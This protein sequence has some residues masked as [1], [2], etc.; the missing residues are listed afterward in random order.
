MHPRPPASSNPAQAPERRFTGLPASPGVAIGP[1]VL[2]RP[3]ESIV[4][5]RAIVLE[6]VPAEIDRL[7]EAL[8]RT[9]QQLMEARQKLL[10]QAQEGEAAV[11]D[12]HLL[13]LEDTTL[14]EAVRQKITEQLFNADYAYE[15]LARTYAK[16]MRALE[17][18][19]LAE[20]AVDI[21]DVCRRVLRN[22]HPTEGARGMDWLAAPGV[23]LAHD[24]SPF[25]IVSLHHQHLLGFATQAGSHTSHTTIM[26]RSLGLPAVVGLDHDLL[27]TLEAG[28]EVLLDG[29]RGLLILNPTEETRLGYRI[30]QERRHAD[31]SRLASLRRL[32]TVTLDGHRIRLLANAGLPEDLPVLQEHG[33]EGIG[34]YR[35]EFLYLNRSE[36]PSE[37]EQLE[38]YRQ[39]AQAIA[40]HPL[41]IRTF[42]LGVDKKLEA[43]PMPEEVNPAL[44]WRGIRLCLDRSDLFQTQLRAI[45]RTAMEY[46]V[47]I[48]LPMVATLEEVHAARRAIDRARES[49]VS[50]GTPPPP[51]V[52]LGVMVEVPSVAIAAELF[53]PEVQFFSL[54]TNDLIQY[55]MAADRTNERTAQL[56]QPTHPAVLRL[57][58]MVAQAGRKHHV[59]VTVCGEMA[60]D[61][62]LAPV[63]AGLGVQNLSLHAPQIPTLKRALRSITLAKAAQLARA[64]LHSTSQE[65]SRE[66]LRKF[67]RSAYPDLMEESAV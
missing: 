56:Y 8:V 32:P 16:K 64:L 58:Q 47:Q 67:A 7:E 44:G 9:R 30:Q 4:A 31:Q 59:P 62:L 61:L 41:T 18:A 35:T 1:L 38:A 60:G 45:L 2:L 26:A 65:A 34:L 52:P 49:L 43:F 25:E 14:L 50:R 66:R 3:D 36:L 39:A 27:E 22:F 5:R 37:E 23:L 48:L 17:D 55:T 57:I 6:E 10:N 33:A 53:A 19:Y 28:A 15:Q 51:A 46:P 12:V 21:L 11:F 63:L 42:D 13:V 29:H 24:I 20:R 40:P 54:G